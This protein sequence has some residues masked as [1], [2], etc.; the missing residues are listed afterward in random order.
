MYRY[1]F[2]SKSRDH[3]L[4]EEP[5]GAILHR[6]LQ[7]LRLMKE[8]F[9]GVVFK[10]FRGRV[11]PP[12]FAKLDLVLAVPHQSNPDLLG[13]LVEGFAHVL[14]NHPEPGTRIRCPKRALRVEVGKGGLRPGRAEPV[15][16]GPALEVGSKLL[17]AVLHLDDFQ[18]GWLRGTTSRRPVRKRR[19]AFFIGR[20]GE[21]LFAGK[22]GRMRGPPTPLAE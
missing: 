13:Q 16:G 15:G 18:L 21:V 20:S 14:L 2:I 17:V 9:P 1:L 7:F 12:E 6:V 4:I 10:T 3:F 8:G 5:S 11:S 22:R 19:L